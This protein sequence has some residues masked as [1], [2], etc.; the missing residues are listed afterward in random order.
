M[1]LTHAQASQPV[2]HLLLNHFALQFFQ[3]IFSIHNHLP[4]GSVLCPLLLIL[5]EKAKTKTTEG[6][7]KF[8]EG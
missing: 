5:L 7:K 2:A 3:I 8:P 1:H 6:E 4:K